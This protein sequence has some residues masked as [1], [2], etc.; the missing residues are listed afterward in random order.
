VQLADQ[1]LDLLAI[2]HRMP[3]FRYGAS[4]LW[5]SAPI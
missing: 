5:M 3:S 1:L 2:G 4:R